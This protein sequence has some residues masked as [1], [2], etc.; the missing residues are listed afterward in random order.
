MYSYYVVYG[1]SPEGR[2][3]NRIIILGYYQALFLAFIR[4]PKLVAV[5][6]RSSDTHSDH[7]C[8]RPPAAHLA[9]KPLAF[10]FAW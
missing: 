6:I 3:V 9:I 4:L 8:G 10:S 5:A 2:A 7:A 1:F